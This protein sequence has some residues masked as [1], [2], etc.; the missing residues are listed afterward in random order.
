MTDSET[1]EGL[2]DRTI[3]A[4]LHQL[5]QECK[6]VSHDSPYVN[7]TAREF[8]K[9]GGKSH[10]FV[11]LAGGRAEVTSVNLREAGITA[12]DADKTT[13]NVPGL[14]ERLVDD[15]IVLVMDRSGQKLEWRLTSVTEP[16]KVNFGSKDWVL[17]QAV[18]DASGQMVNKGAWQVATGAALDRGRFNSS[19]VDAAKMMLDIATNREAS[20]RLTTT[21]S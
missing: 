8:G 16:G 18:Q 20:N 14:G 2:D 9:L 6:I 4:A 15:Q 12:R 17:S 3:S 10:S 11:D 19:A 7:R 1:G 5:R 21:C 13:I